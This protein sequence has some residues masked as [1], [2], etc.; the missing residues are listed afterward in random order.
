MTSPTPADDQQPWDEPVDER[1]SPSPVDAVVF[2]LG[3]VLIRWDPFAAVVAGVGAAEATAFFA[4]EDF[5]FGAWNYQQ[6]AGRGWE[7]AETEASRTHPHWG[8]ALRAYREHFPRS[9][10]GVFEDTVTV[11][12][13]LHEAGVPLFALTNWSEELFPEA[14]RRFDFLELF[15]DIV[16]SGEEGVAKPDPEIFRVLEERMRHRGSLE[17]TVF[18]DDNPRNVEAATAAGMDAIL[19]T[20]TGH[21]RE[22][23]RARGLPLRRA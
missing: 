4:A 3:N 15:E 16:V 6:D 2:D 1:F 14:L 22:D 21:L 12:R 20:D 17:D 7:E 19:F 5:D 11:L 23:L 8:P 9:L 10:I 18:I 13:E